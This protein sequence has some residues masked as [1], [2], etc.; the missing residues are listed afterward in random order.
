MEISRVRVLLTLLE[1]KEVHR[2]P[3]FR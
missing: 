2:D 1:G 3:G